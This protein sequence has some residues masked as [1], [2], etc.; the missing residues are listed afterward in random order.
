MMLLSGPRAHSLS[1]SLSLAALKDNQ[2]EAIICAEKKKKNR[3]QFLVL[4]CF[5]LFNNLAK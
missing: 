3:Y 1:L 5:I 4:D 2:C